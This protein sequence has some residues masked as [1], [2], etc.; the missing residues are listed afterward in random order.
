MS[1]E[2]LGPLD[3]SVVVPAYNES[4]RIDSSLDAML[5]FLR[6]RME[7]FEILIVDD[8]SDDRTAAS[9]TERR[10]P[11][12]I[13]LQS[14]S[15]HGKG[16]SVR[17]GVARSRGQRVL[18]ADADYP[19]SFEYLTAFERR[20][21]EG[22]DI[23][24]GSKSMPE[25][26]A[27]SAQP[28]HRRPL[29]R[30]FN[31]WVRLLGLSTFRDTQCG[32]KLFRGDVARELFRQSRVDGFVFDVEILFLA[33]SM[34]YRAKEDPVRWSHVPLSQVR[35]LSNGLEMFVDLLRLRIDIWRGRYRPAE[36]VDRG[37]LA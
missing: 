4:R 14:D 32:F 5:G 19:I 1:D 10:E 35:A 28:M 18:L 27:M 8:G 37:S 22:Y 2:D 11:E 31:V 24:C 6:S 3:L 33:R 26:K 15:N 16:A 21:D 7:S 9:V 29:G 20:L 12:V 30:L 13:V 23:V 34:G 25:S 36:P 17:K